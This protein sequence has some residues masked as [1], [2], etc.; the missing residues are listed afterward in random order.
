MLP[1]L[2]TSDL[3]VRFLHENKQDEGLVEIEVMNACACERHMPRF[4][5]VF[6]HHHGILTCFVCGWLVV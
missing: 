6:V 1:Q 4:A 3:V 5:W 2:S